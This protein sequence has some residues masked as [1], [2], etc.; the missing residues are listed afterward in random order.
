M[1]P[2]RIRAANDRAGTRLPI[3]MIKA[4]AAGGRR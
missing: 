2:D 3:D 4:L 1:T